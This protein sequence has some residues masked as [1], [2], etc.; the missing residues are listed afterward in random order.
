MTT[1]KGVSETDE[2]FIQDSRSFVGND[3]LW[4]RPNGNGYTTVLEEAGI[5]SHEEAAGKRPSD[6][7]WP[8]QTIRPL[9]RSTIDMQDLRDIQ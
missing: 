4:W 2:Y 5:Y 7:A 1:F 8:I 9:V 3:V 6:I